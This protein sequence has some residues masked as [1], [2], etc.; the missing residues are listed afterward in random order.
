ME[1]PYDNWLLQRVEYL[2]EDDEVFVGEAGI[3]VAHKE[4]LPIRR[5][6]IN[7]PVAITA[8]IFLID[9]GML[10]WYWVRFLLYR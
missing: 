9:L 7:W 6:A 1:Y 3:T 4:E 5:P 8:V 2:E 10:V